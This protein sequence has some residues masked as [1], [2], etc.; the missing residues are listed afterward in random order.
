MSLPVFLSCR[1]LFVSM[2]SS[3]PGVIVLILCG[4]LRRRILGSSPFRFPIRS[5]FDVVLGRG[6]LALVGQALRHVLRGDD[7]GFDRHRLLI[8]VRETGLPRVVS[9]HFRRRQPRAAADIASC[10]RRRDGPLDYIILKF[11]VF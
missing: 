4:W 7:P 8:R 5:P 3:R 11:L 9:G 6:W 2:L 10:S 1:Q